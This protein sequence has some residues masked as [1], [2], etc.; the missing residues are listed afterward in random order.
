VSAGPGGR[1]GVG[2]PPRRLDTGPRRSILLTAWG[3]ALA[4]ELRPLA[5]R[6]P[7]VIEEGFDEAESEPW[8]ECCYG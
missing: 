3:A 8:A 7:T 1:S 6:I 2:V 5:L 4:R